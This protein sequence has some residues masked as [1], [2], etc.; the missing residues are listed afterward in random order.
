MNFPLKE[1]ELRQLYTERGWEHF[2][3][4]AH[5][6]EVETALEEVGLLPSPPRGT[7]AA[8]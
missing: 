2:L 8:R 1:T 7:I 6:L 5:R 4:H 3:T